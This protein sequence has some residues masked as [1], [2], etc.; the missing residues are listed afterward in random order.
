[1]GV[2]AG[3]E[4]RP[5]GPAG[6]RSAE[7]L[8]LV[9]LAVLA[10]AVLWWRWVGFQGHDDATYAAAALEWVG[11]E[12]PVGHTHWALRYPLVLPIAGVIRLTG[13]SVAAM[14]SVN[15][16]AYLA[17]LVF[18]YLA[19]RHW[20]GWQAGVAVSV[21]GIVL[22]EFPVQA[23]YANPDL[24]EMVF[25]MASFWLF[26]LARA[27]RGPVGVLVASGALAGLGFVTRETTLSLLLVFGLIWLVRPG[28]G[29]LRYA[30]MALGFLAVVGA[31]TAY[32]VVRT[33]DPLY[34]A[35]ISATHD[36]VDRTAKVAEAEAAGRTLDNEGTIAAGPVASPLLA[37]FVSQKFGLLFLLTIP[38]YWLLRRGKR[39][40]AA[41]ASVVDCMGLGSLVSFLFVAANAEILYVVPR[42]FIVS[43]AMAAVPLAVLAADWLGRPGVRRVVAGLAALAFV[44]SSALL[45]YL[46]NTDPLRA[47]KQVLAFAAAAPVP[48]H[49]DAELMRRSHYLVLADGLQDRVTTASP[50]PGDLVG[51]VN[52]TTQTACLRNPVCTERGR[53]AGF[54]PGPDWTVVARFEPPVR[55]IAWPLG[56]LGLSTMLP[57]DVRAKVERPGAEAVVYRVP[58]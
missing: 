22:P 27:R 55:A 36:R 15:V 9:T 10:V 43:A 21:I 16:S 8:W 20:F 53:Q 47:E 54:L 35:H 42:Y 30:W 29:R 14:A 6:N 17:F 51:V 56:W 31:Q 44:G 1:M 19:A 24:L 32:F 7:A 26:L 12:P 3:S 41:Q 18:S 37:I 28:M 50:G 57:R 11:G 5:L 40:S 23:T 38:A 58:G 52:D 4:R 46:E 25:V 49:L 2:A 13:I 34:R 39:L 45:L 33:G 48:L